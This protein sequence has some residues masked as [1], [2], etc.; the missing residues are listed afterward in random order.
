M[1][2][3]TDRYKDGRYIRKEDTKYEKGHVKEPESLAD[4]M[5]RE[6]EKDKKQ[7][8]LETLYYVPGI[9]AA[10]ALRRKNGL[11]FGST[12]A[13]MEDRE[14]ECLEI[15][16]HIS[17]EDRKALGNMV[18]DMKRL[19]AEIDLAQH[20]NDQVRVSGALAQW[21]NTKSAMVLY[22]KNR[23]ISVK[24][25]PKKDVVKELKKTHVI[26]QNKEQAKEQTLSNEEVKEI[27][28]RRAKEASKGR[29][30]ERT[31]DREGEY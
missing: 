18:K 7:E 25:I 19:D 11:F 1:E 14:T 17:Q 20:Q 26:Q 21:E 16:G 9:H 23:N 30:L 28:K 2:A 24:S 29:V 5:N 22:L 6:S 10:K 4:V 3:N 27:K 13:D 12:D 8:P 15:S 31:M